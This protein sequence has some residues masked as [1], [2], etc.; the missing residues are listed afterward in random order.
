MP[1]KSFATKKE[2]HRDKKKK[3]ST[4]VFYV[5][6]YDAC[7]THRSHPIL[8]LVGRSPK[9]EKGDLLAY[10]DAKEGQNVARGVNFFCTFFTRRTQ[11]IDNPQLT[12]AIKIAKRHP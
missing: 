11:Y 5:L 6:F 8:K 2:G 10:I 3:K 12:S 4:S 7:A 1:R 9:G